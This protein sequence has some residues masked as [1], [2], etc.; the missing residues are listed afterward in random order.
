VYYGERL[1]SAT[2]LI[3]AL[4]SV[5]AMSVLMTMASLQN[6]AWKLVSFA[7]YGL[8]L[9]LLYSCSTIYHSVRSPRAKSL[10]Q[11]LDHN[12][13]YLLIAGS[14]TPFCLVT[15]R[16]PWGW[17]LFATG[18]GLALIGI[19]QEL[20]LGRRTRRL[21]MTIYLLMGWMVIV[22]IEPLLNALPLGGLIWLAAGGLVYSLGIYFYLNDT[23][24]R[25]F[26]GVWHLFVLAGSACHF[27]CV[28]L[29][30]A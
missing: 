20:T 24:F 22:A 1:N 10:L 23:R 5:A 28:L 17:T 16:G 12:A 8:T 7:V 26:H 4:L 21:S 3:G 15:L 2:H 30:V 13:I 9:V 27:V 11:K 25:H 19:A 29:Y 18:W 14:Y 6:D